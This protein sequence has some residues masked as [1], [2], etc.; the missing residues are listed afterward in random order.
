M[1][2]IKALEMEL[3]QLRTSDMPAPAPPP[4]KPKYVSEEDLS[5]RFLELERGGA[6]MQAAGA[7]RGGASGAPLRPVPDRDVRGH[8]ICD[9]L[10][11]LL[12]EISGT[13]EC[14]TVLIGDAVGRSSQVTSR[15]S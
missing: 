13:P 8:R 1:Q 14:A 12:G 9:V 5:D 3:I 15:R 4:P 2:L 6:A 10:I 7:G 11:W